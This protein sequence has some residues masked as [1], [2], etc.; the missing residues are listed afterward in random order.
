ML[1]SV[2]TAADTVLNKAVNSTPGVPGVV[3]VAT[4]R[5][6][7]IYAG[8]FGVRQAGASAAMTTA[9]TQNTSK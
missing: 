5:N 8:A 7:N 9:N 2:K 1:Q 4:D 3:A 6:A